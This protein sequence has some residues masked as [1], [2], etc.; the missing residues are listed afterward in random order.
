MSHPK[1]DPTDAVVIPADADIKTMMRLSAETSSL[2]KCVR[3]EVPESCRSKEPVVLGID[4]AG[5]GPVLGPMIY[6]AAYWRVEDEESISALDFDDS[7]QL[8]AEKREKMLSTILEN[9]ARI[10]WVM[11]VLSAR[12]ISN[13]MLR[14]NPV[15]LN[16]VSYVAA[17]NMIRAAQ[18]AGVNV[19]KVIVDTVGDPE[20]YE[21]L[22]TRAFDGT[23]DFCVRKKADALFKVV[24]AASICAKVTRD[25]VLE[26]WEFPESG[27][28]VDAGG[29]DGL[30]SGYPGD[31][32]TKKWLRASADRV[33]GFPSIVRFSWQT[34]KTLLGD[35]HGADASSR[36][37]KPKQDKS[38]ATS[39]EERE[40]ALSV[41]VE[42]EDLEEDE[43]QTKLTGFFVKKAL[44]T[45]V[46][47][48]KKKR[49]RCDF[50]ERRALK[51]LTCIV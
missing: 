17:M 45:G 31:E 15:S 28:S 46:G 30:G 37:A 13:K 47:P 42:W 25:F 32:R 9:N 7:K 43:R 36:W 33:F 3:S 48:K 41:R 50:F 22:L 51:P 29:V 24:G 19:V 5:R 14:R 6:G 26:T 27:Q 8:S 44:G 39:G 40:P 49:K 38:N 12:E 2:R 35:E 4:E 20:T 10:G 11:R 21:R 34:T 16:K 1:V 23:I 18:N